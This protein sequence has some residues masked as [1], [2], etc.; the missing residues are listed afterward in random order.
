M[1][2]LGWKLAVP[3]LYIWGAEAEEGSADSTVS[4]EGPRRRGAPLTLFC[5]WWG[6][7]LLCLLCGLP[8]DTS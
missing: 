2:P 4:L 7:V 5:V 1:S 3:P 6:L 8:G